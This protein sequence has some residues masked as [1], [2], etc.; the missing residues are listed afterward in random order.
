MQMHKIVRENYSYVVV[1]TGM[2]AMIMVYGTTMLSLGL[3]V[4]PMVNYFGFSYASVSA[5]MSF[6]A[7]GAI[8]G[9]KLAAVVI[10]KK[11][12]KCCMIV[13]AALFSAA[14]FSLSQCCSLW[15]FY[16]F[17][18]VLGI[19]EAGTSTIP[20]SVLVNNWVSS[21]RRGAAIGI[22]YMGS[23]IGGLIFSPI[24]NSIIQNYGWNFGFA[25][26]GIVMAA[27]YLPV[28]SV[29]TVSSPEQFYKSEK[30]FAGKSLELQHKNAGIR[31]EDA[32]KTKLFW[33]IGIAILLLS[34]CSM[35]FVFH[36]SSYFISIGCPS[37][38]A[39]FLV[40]ISSACIALAK[41]MLGICADKTAPAT[42]AAIGFASLGFGLLTLCLLPFNS[43]FF[44]P[45]IIFSGFGNASVSVLTP[46]IGNYFFG[47]RD[48]TRIMGQLS[49]LSSVGNAAGPLFTGMVLDVTGS[50]RGAF[51]LLAILV[52][53]AAVRT[54]HAMVTLRRREY[55]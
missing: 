18:V 27:V 24:I 33:E 53:A 41:M 37:Q 40:G 36:L 4:V 12:V 43:L 7:V 25:F 26:I 34:A 10:R 45:V 32:I 9:S 6:K 54:V 47:E 28:I 19:A 21:S 35:S 16:F 46:I 29:F 30:H 50:Y 23:G 52:F 44:I 55:D 31:Y 15:Q 5:I 11:S 51:L 38:K 14:A 42:A 3:F 1:L 49:M 8:I 20:I 48:F 39:A 17:A 22:S 13:F 2:L